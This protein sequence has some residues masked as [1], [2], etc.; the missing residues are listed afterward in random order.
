MV[1]KQP[2]SGNRSDNSYLDRADSWASFFLL[3]SYFSA[4]YCAACFWLLG[5]GRHHKPTVEPV[6]ITWLP[7]GE[8]VTTTFPSAGL[9]VSFIVPVALA[10]FLF[11][12]CNH[13]SETRDNMDWFSWTLG[14]SLFLGIFALSSMILSGIMAPARLGLLFSGR[15]C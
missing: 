11:H 15:Y 9:T 4:F 5:I 2:P 13:F 14:V 7:I 6:T 12:L 8:A 3:S 1:P 10:V